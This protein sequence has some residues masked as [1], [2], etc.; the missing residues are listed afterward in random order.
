M[1]AIPDP[2]VLRSGTNQAEFL[3]EEGQKKA[4]QT[5][6]ES[7]SEEEKAE[8][9]GR[10]SE[11]DSGGNGERN[12]SSDAGVK[13]ANPGERQCWRTGGRQ[14]GERRRKTRW[15]FAGGEQ[16]PET[17]RKRQLNRPWP[18]SGKS[19]AT[20]GVWD[21]TYLIRGRGRRRKPMATERE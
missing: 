18:R 2:D 20:A 3:G 21:R 12:S 1:D 6:T 15:R 7:S 19:V 4:L 14:R 11:S 10:E 9:G 13:T 5:A 8:R 17:R 16:H